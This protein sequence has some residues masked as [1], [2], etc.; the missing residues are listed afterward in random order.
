[1]Y[2]KLNA[3]KALIWRIVHKDNL[4]W[5][6][7]NGLYC[8]NSTIRIP[9]YTPVGNIE[10][11]NKRK[12]KTVPLSP[13]GT[14]SDYIP[15]YFTPFSPMM[16]NIHTGR[17]VPKYHNNKIII[18]VSS[19]RAVAK[20]NIKFLFTDRHALCELANYFNSLDELINIDWLLLQKRDFQRDPED[21]EK[22]ERYQAEA[23][24]HQHLPISGLEG[25]VC[26]SNELELQ[27]KQ[28]INMKGLTLQV[29]T[30]PEWYFE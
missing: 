25:I 27:I 16:L 26:Y 4:S 10:L 14:L 30:R 13:G 15:F 17:G 24:V 22:M 11:I 29:L 23:L 12:N 19:L 21:L 3:E 20:N 6:L 9:N 28:E 18:L 7:D 2:K 1:M 8:A 5:I